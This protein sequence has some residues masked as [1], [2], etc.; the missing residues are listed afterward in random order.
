M[1]TGVNIVHSVTLVVKQ[2]VSVLVHDVLQM[3]ILYCDCN[4][5]LSHV[6]ARTMYPKYENPFV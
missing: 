1:S 2:C 3:Y 4:T 6:F 5:E